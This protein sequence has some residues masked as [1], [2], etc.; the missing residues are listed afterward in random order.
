MLGERKKKIYIYI[1]YTYSIYPL[2]SRSPLGSFCYFSSRGRNKTFE[3]YKTVKKRI[4]SKIRLKPNRSQ[5]AI[6]VTD[7][8]FRRAFEPIQTQVNGFLFPGKVG[9]WQQNVREA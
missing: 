5:S 1:H 4:L 9:L 6:P 2:R 7:T 8:R 3:K